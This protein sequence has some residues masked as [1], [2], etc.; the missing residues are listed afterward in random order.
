MGCLVLGLLL[1]VL[2]LVDN[3]LVSVLLGSKCSLALLDFSDG[4]FSES[5]FVLRTGSL[6]LFDIV[7][8][9]S[10]NGSFLSEDFLL[11]VL[12]GIGLL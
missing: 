4:F 2:V 8:G 1:D 11:L 3:L 9:D 12:A 6:D 10:L 7:K 5:L